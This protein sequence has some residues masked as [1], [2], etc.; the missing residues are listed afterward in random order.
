MCL[1][2]LLLFFREWER[3]VLW[4]F[5]GPRVPQ[6]LCHLWSAVFSWF[7]RTPE[8]DRLALA[9]ISHT[10]TPAWLA[11]CRGAR[12]QRPCR[13]LKASHAETVLSEP[14]FQLMLSVLRRVSLSALT[15]HP[16]GPVLEKA[17]GMW[18]MIAELEGIMRVFRQRGTEA[19]A[20]LSHH[21]HIWSGKGNDWEP[22][23]SEGVSTCPQHTHTHTDT[24]GP[25]SLLVLAASP[26]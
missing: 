17:W 19:Q 20:F 8:E 16:Q 4:D 10:D 24:K 2:A 18:V 22:C 5:V 7:C 15:S 6:G 14:P 13:Y 21:P 11:C 1:Y 23:L 26:L 9:L 3:E 12:A 25:F